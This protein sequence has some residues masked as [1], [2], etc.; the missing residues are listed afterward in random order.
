MLVDVASSFITVGFSDHTLNSAAANTNLLI[1][2][3]AFA[4]AYTW[5]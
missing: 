1:V 4:F 5:D 2:P 3:E